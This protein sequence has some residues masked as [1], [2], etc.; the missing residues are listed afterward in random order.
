MSQLPKHT[1]LLSPFHSSALRRTALVLL[2]S[3][4]LASTNAQDIHFSQFFLTD[5]STNPAAAGD[6]DGEYRLSGAHR[7]QWKS[8]TTPYSTFQLS[9][10]A[11]D[12][13]RVR[14]FGIGFRVLNDK[15]GDSQLHTLAG[16]FI[17]SGITKL[18]ADSSTTLHTGLEIGYTQMRIDYSALRYDEQ[19]T[20]SIFDPSLPTGE[21]GLRNSLGHLDAHTGIYIRHKID[22][23]RSWSIGLSAWNLTNPAVNFQ[24][25]EKVRLSQRL[26]IHGDYVHRISA[27]WDIIPSARAMWQGVYQE[28]LVGARVSHTLRKDAFTDRR[29]L[30]GIH[31]R[32][33]DAAY[34][35]LGMRHD[36]WDVGLSY[37]INL[38][39]LV[40]ASRNRGA[41]EVVITRRFDVFRE[42]RL[43]HRQCFD[44]L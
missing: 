19:F 29:L 22:R 26:A 20:G 18:N 37:D 42:T 35:S 39:P 21:Q 41:F 23:Y 12:A 6:F 38:S 4:M 16:S 27:R 44:F 43:P 9:A 15:A 13:F 40:V 28:L 8:V 17:V 3:S 2:C 11:S 5:L 10:D 30:F 36:D 31:G 1:W 33:T 32:A 14:N 7:N 25:D 34:V 24:E